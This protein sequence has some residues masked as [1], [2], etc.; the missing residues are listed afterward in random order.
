[1]PIPYSMNVRAIYEEISE[2]S[3]KLHAKL[4][5]DERNSSI[6]RLYALILELQRR[7]QV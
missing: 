5:T 6:K 4:P 7:F 1:M 2:I 3:D